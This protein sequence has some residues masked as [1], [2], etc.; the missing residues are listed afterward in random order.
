MHSCCL[1]YLVT[2]HIKLLGWIQGFTSWVLL[3]ATKNMCHKH[4]SWFQLL[5]YKV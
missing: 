2:V 5:S 1:D 3:N 4:I